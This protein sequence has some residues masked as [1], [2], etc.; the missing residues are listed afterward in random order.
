M[1]EPEEVAYLEQLPNQVQ[2]VIF[3]SFL[4][5]EF[6]CKHKNYFLLTKDTENASPDEYSKFYTWYDPEYR[7]FMLMTL[8]KLEPRFER[9][10]TILRDELDEADEI[11]FVNKGSVAIGYEING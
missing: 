2:D 8:Q 10:R 7:E 3:S 11:L 5:D 6:L 4:F 1:D 9:K